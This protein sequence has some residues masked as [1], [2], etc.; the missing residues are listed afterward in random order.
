[1]FMEYTLISSFNQ[2]RNKAFVSYSQFAQ[3]WD[4]A[5]SAYKSLK[6]ASDKIKLVLVSGIPGS[7]KSSFG[8]YLSKLFAKESIQSST[9]IMPVA[10]ST[11]FTSDAFLNG[12]FKHC[13]QN[14][15]QTVVAVIPSYHHLKKAIFEFKKDTKFNDLFNL[16][17][18]ITKVSAKNF[19]KHE[20]RN[21]YQFMLENCLK[22]ICDAVIFE[23][24]NQSQEDFVQMRKEL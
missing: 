9:F 19:Y 13:E 15:T 12:L 11:K 4:T 14:P 10:E 23:K 2:I 5:Q 7:G 24:G 20:N 16:E 6:E 22:G 8:I 21:T 17:Y 3:I 18:V 1:M